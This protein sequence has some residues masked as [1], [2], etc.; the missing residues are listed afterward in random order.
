[1]QMAEGQPD[2]VITQWATLETLS[3]WGFLVSPES[4]RCQDVDEAIAFHQALKIQRNSLPVEIDGSVIKV[5]QID[6]QNQLGNVARSPRWAI[7]YKFPPEQTR[8]VVMTIEAQVGRTGALTP[9]AKLEPVQV[10]GVTVS[11]TSLHNQDEI[12]R[13]D[14]REGDA[15]IIQRAGDVIPQL[16]RVLL[17]ER[18]LDS[19]EGRIYERYTL[20]GTC[21]ICKATT[22]RLEAESVTRCPNI[23]CPAQLK[24]NLR[25]M[26]SRGALD[27]DGL[28]EKLIEQLVDTGLVERL[29]DL[30]TLTLDPLQ[31]LE[32][33]GEKSATN[34]IASL[35]RSRETTLPRLLISL[36]IRHVGETVAETLAEHFRDIEPLMRATS[37]EIEA[38][39]GIGPTIAESVSRFF[40]DTANQS[41]IKR[42]IE[43]GLS[44]PIPEVVN[45]ETEGPLEGLTFV[46]TGSLSAPR[47]DF[48]KRIESAGGKVVG[49]VSKNT[50]YLVAGEK[51]GSKLKKA[52]DLGVE[53]LDEE[54]LEK[55]L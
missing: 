26:A 34:L 42:L 28:G 13:K 32:R 6:L 3:S 39:H 45:L 25:H 30:F 43:L 18:D 21:P 46:L 8:S 49:T 51:A 5:D 19:N 33:M 54:G 22:I 55:L 47:G 53:V 40:A 29:S 36:G 52:L 1:M 37:S 15:V 50:D 2:E 31:G 23:D 11:S 48:K 4:K 35:E 38:T 41:E 16:V 12:D 20:P 9:V 44:W 7:A 17:D 24:N 10:G 27:I 14:I